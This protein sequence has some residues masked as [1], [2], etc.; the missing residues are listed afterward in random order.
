MSACG[1]AYIFY[2]ALPFITLPSILD[3]HLECTWGNCQL[4]SLGFAEGKTM[5]IAGD[6]SPDSS[7]CYD[8]DTQ[9]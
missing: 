5:I 1:F 7:L 8:L 3:F 4:K 9:I 2:W 6:P